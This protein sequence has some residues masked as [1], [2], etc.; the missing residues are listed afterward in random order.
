M[1]D[2]AEQIFAALRAAGQ[3]WLVSQSSE[4]CF[5]GKQQRGSNCSDIADAGR[6]CEARYKFDIG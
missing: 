6:Y 5:R 4:R 3:G 2:A 1:S